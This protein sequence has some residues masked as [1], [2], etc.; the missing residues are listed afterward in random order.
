[1]N[2]YCFY[3]NQTLCCT[4][5]DQEI[6]YDSEAKQL[7]RKFDTYTIQF[8]H[9]TSRNIRIDTDHGS[10]TLINYNEILNSEFAF[11]LRNT[12]ARIYQEIAKAQR[13][14]NHKAHIKNLKLVGGA[15][16]GLLALTALVAL[17]KSKEPA[18]IVIDHVES[19]NIPISTDTKENTKVQI[20]NTD[21]FNY[22]W[23]EDLDA[24]L[25][26][27]DFDQERYSITGEYAYNTYY[28]MTKPLANKW[29]IQ[30]N[31]A[32][33]MLTQESAGKETN[34]MQIEF[35]AWAEKDDYKPVITVYNFDTNQYE[36]FLLTDHPENHIGENIT[37]ITRKDLEN[38]KTNISV[39]MI[40]LRQS[41]NYMHGHIGAGI[42]CYNY[43][44]GNMKKVLEKTEKETGC[45]VDEILRDQQNLSFMKYT[46]VV[47]AGDPEY[48]NHIVRYVENIEDGISIKNVNDYGEIDQNVVYIASTISR[49][50]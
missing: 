31:L 1:M 27:L 45:P 26:Y 48:L 21:Q 11:C 41:I 28:D 24:P 10:Y 33:A 40:L 39:A 9:V 38:P 42:Q 4:Q 2:N 32:I 20:E 22:E 35:D 50:K 6:M 17:A 19:G 14:K 13:R 25:T 43:G 49:Q 47:Q 5:D 36:K 44:Y 16:V 7:L 30:P 18:E 34:L 15:T 12:E 37:C 3:I 29:G 46:N 23:D 8:I